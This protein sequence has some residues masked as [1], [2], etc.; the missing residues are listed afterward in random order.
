MLVA[1]S[2]SSY[3]LVLKAH[4]DARL[5][6]A[7]VPLVTAVT[8]DGTLPVSSPPGVFMTCTCVRVHSG[9]IF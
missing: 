6:C 5:E 8:G 2:C 9:S 7:V 1:T 4:R 3:K